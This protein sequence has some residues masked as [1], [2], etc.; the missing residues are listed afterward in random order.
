MSAQSSAPKFRILKVYHTSGQDVVTIAV[1][2]I[3]GAFQGQIKDV[4]TTQTA[5]TKRIAARRRQAFAT[6]FADV[7]ELDARIVNFGVD[8]INWGDDEIIDEARQLLD[9]FGSELVT[10]P[11]KPAVVEP[12]RA[13]PI[14]EPVKA[15]AEESSES[16]S[17]PK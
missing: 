3:D 17:N 2:A 16:T 4:Y 5:L 13:E 10:E 6:E 11:E 15:S 14:E 12:A 8:L 1:M 9:A 7:A